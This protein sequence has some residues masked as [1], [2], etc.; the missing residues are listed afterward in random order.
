M[1]G[2]NRVVSLALLLVCAPTGAA[3]MTAHFI[4]VGQ[5]AATLLEF[6]C[7]TV[8]IDLGG[9]TVAST[10]FSSN[11]KLRAY[12]ERFFDDRPGRPRRLDLVVLSHP[13]ID[14][15]RGKAE[16]LTSN[17]PAE[18]PYEILNVLDD[19]L[20]TS[21]GASQQKALRK[22]GKD[23][24]HYE[25][26]KVANIPGIGLT[27]SVI[28]PIACADVDPVIRV[29][30]GRLVPRPSTWSQEEYKNE[31][32]HSVVVR[33]DFGAASFLFPGDI[34][35]VAELKLLEK[36]T[37]T[38]LLD[39]DVYQAAHHG[40][41]T[42]SLEPFL[43]AISPQIIVIPM[44]DPAR[45]GSFT[46]RAHGHPRQVCVNRLIA[47]T[48]D[49]RPPVQVPVALGQ[50]NFDIVTMTKAIYATGWDGDVRIVTDSNGT[51][52]PQTD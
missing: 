46:A 45:T 44:G 21:L 6:S 22:W 42:S 12:L 19:T 32:N 5:G 13:H 9:E 15:V 50:N 24:G 25:G 7:G 30:W 36:Y 4:D 17:D 26:I 20:N 23:H 27:S 38:D 33:V 49:S 35:D 31:N 39:V 40:S 18:V 43:I 41:A 28:D 37:G 14:H 29:L 47:H 2:S 3:T 51:Y 10:G 16:L 8:L 48:S 1:S 34:E 52:I 11:Q